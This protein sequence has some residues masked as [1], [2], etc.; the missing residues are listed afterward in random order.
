[1]HAHIPAMVGDFFWRNLVH[2]FMN[3]FDNRT[4]CI[5]IARQ[6]H[7]ARQRACPLFVKGIEG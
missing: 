6:D 4:K 3:F 1:M 7:P 5:L 2:K